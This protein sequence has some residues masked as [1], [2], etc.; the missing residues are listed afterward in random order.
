MEDPTQADCEQRAEDETTLSSVD[1]FN[2][3]NQETV[4]T[5][6]EQTQ[7]GF[8]P[9]GEFVS[10]KTEPSENEGQVTPAEPTN[11]TPD[12]SHCEEQGDAAIQ[13]ETPQETEAPAEDTI[14]Y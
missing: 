5:Q 11:E 4:E 6:D 8:T 7:N 10:E 14:P 13:T 12:S 2:A 1:S 9:E 3:S